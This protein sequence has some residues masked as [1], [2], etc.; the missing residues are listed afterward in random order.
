MSIKKAL[1]S[2]TTDK[3]SQRD[4]LVRWLA[5]RCLEDSK[6]TG[7]SPYENHVWHKLIVLARYEGIS[8]ADVRKWSRST[9]G[10]LVADIIDGWRLLLQQDVK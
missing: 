4:L 2:L 1:E 7:V 8:D 10:K 5:E 3:P 6:E 9:L